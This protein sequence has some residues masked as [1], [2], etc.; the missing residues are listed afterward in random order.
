LKFAKELLKRYSSIK[1]VLE[2]SSKFSGRLRKMKTNYL[3]G[4]KNKEVFETKGYVEK[5]KS[6][7]L[8]IILDKLYKELQE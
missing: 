8:D 5:I 3:A 6:E 4:E 1:T 7:D 2:K